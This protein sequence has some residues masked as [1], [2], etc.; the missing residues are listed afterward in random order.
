MKAESLARLR[1]S[2]DSGLLVDAVAHA[3]RSDGARI[4][5]F[6][7]RPHPRLDGD[8]PLDLATSSSAGTEAVLKLLLRAEAG[9]AV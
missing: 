2:D 4:E 7:T 6:L 9:V 5:G 1:E 8:S 3:F